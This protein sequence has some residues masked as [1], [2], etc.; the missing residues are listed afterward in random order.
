MVLKFRD[1]ARFE[2]GRVHIRHISGDDG[3]TRSRVPCQ[4]ACQLKNTQVLYHSGFSLEWLTQSFKG[5][6]F[7]NRK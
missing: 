5:D 7:R 2:P 3:L 4:A 6:S 1:I